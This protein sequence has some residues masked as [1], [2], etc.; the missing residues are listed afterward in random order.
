M[1][2]HSFRKAEVVASTPTIGCVNLQEKYNSLQ[3]ILKDIGKA[4]IAFSGGVDS[5]LLS[6][7]AVDTLRA[8]NVLA[9]I[10]TGPSLPELIQ[11]NTQTQ[12]PAS[13]GIFQPAGNLIEITF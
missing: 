4:V 6:K 3:Q 13:T 11:A 7:V 8:E 12:I 9:C 2:E 10:A 5:T 1:V